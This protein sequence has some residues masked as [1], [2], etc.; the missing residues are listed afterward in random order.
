MDTISNAVAKS[1]QKPKSEPKKAKGEEDEKEYDTLEKQLDDLSEENKEAPANI[2]SITHPGPEAV[3]EKFE[4]DNSV[5]PPLQTI[6]CG[7]FENE[8]IIEAAFRSRKFTTEQ[9][10][11]MIL[12]Y[13][14]LSEK[15]NDKD[16]LMLIKCL[17]VYYKLDLVNQYFEILSNNT[18]EIKK[19]QTKLSEVYD[20]RIVK[21]K[22]D[23]YTP[24][25]FLTDVALH[26]IEIDSIPFM[27]D[28]LEAQRFALSQNSALII[29]EIFHSFLCQYEAGRLLT[30]MHDKFLIITKL[31]KL[32]ITSSTSVIKLVRIMKNMMAS[33]SFL[34]FIGNFYNPLRLFVAILKAFRAMNATV[35]SMEQEFD[36]LEQELTTI[37]IK[38]IDEVETPGVLINW[39]YDDSDE[40]LKVIDYLSQFRCYT[41]LNH[42][43]IVK[44]VN[45]IFL[46]NYDWGKLSSPTVLF[47][48]TPLVKVLRTKEKDADKLVS[49]VGSHGC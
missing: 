40:A 12:Y 24:D 39:L 37:M 19:F 3:A 11:S 14:P 1:Y 41:F 18:S 34:N 43:K 47:F 42:S 45:H 49:I 32:Y 48:S 2:E 5:L 4:V 35:I 17:V 25:M 9:E 44:A 20:I 22:N 13:Y 21:R 7:Y 38:I 36:M 30:Y 6:D 8:V 28:L 10:L 16:R 15:L 26:A 29:E 27:L 31:A 23:D 33:P 46:G